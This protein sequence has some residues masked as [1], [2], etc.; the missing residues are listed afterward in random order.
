M[1]KSCVF[2]K[3]DNVLVSV[4]GLQKAFK[5]GFLGNGSLPIFKEK[6]YKFKSMIVLE[7]EPSSTVV[8]DFGIEGF[9][10]CEDVNFSKSVVDDFANTL[11]TSSTFAK[12]KLTENF[13]GIKSVV[14][15]EG[16]FTAKENCFLV[17]QLED[18]ELSATLTVKKGSYF[19]IEEIETTNEIV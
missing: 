15:L 10:N 3:E 12:Q 18:V 11:K 5:E 14:F 4:L 13:S 2:Q 16:T 6:N 17:P 7:N 9:E 1:K 8:S 19:E